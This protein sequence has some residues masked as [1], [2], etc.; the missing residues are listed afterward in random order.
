M[1]KKEIIFLLTFKSDDHGALHYFNQNKELIKNFC[2]SFKNIYFVNSDYLTGNKKNKKNYKKLSS[3]IGKKIKLFT[4]KDFNSFDLF[5][6]NKNPI[7]IDNTGRVFKYYRL[8]FY[9][10]RKKIP[11]ITI[12]NLGSLQG[13]HGTFDYSYNF[14]INRF[15]T[16]KFP[17]KIAT[18]LSL[19]GIFP[20]IDIYFTSNKSYNDAY[21]KSFFSFLSIYNDH[22][23]VKS[24]QYD[25]KLYINKKTL[26]ED[27]ILLLDMD[28]DH[29][30]FV[31]DIR[32]EYRNESGEISQDLLNEHYS[33]LSYLLDNLSKIFRKKIIISIHPTYSLNNIRN[34]FKK[35]YPVIKYKTKELIKRS[36]LVLFFDSGAII[37]AV[38]FKKKIICLRSKLTKG[39]KYSSDFYQKP[40]NLKA[41]NIN[42]KLNIDKNSLT[43]ELNSKLKFYDK[44]L[45]KYAGSNLKISGNKKIIETIKSRYF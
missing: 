8:L 13:G 18:I 9:L 19:I 36:F 44:Y 1:K 16:K 45:K 12:S 30:E 26:K 25:D 28:M 40:L 39:K 27:I 37:D 15:L 41:I 4:P 14:P 32:K 33:K 34:R 5:L 17:Q 3:V 2:K 35:K 22:I 43:K 23:L 10:K 31:R 11:L 24:K 42:K 7:I 38:V 21:K 20:K 29:Y 6:K